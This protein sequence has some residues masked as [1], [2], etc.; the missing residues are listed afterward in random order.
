M[1]GFI[2][3]LFF[4]WGGCVG[5][6]TEGFVV[7]FAF[8]ICW[9]ARRE[10]QQKPH[11]E[12]CLSFFTRSVKNNSTNNLLHIINTIVMCSEINYIIIHS[13][14]TKFQLQNFVTG[15]ICKSNRWP[16][17]DQQVQFYVKVV[18]KNTFPTVTRMTDI[19]ISVNENSTYI[20]QTFIS[21]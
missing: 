9:G 20:S 3:F 2:Y 14:E 16:W 15:M 18:Q 17:R 19:I 7:Q 21:V 12:P 5:S 1:L 6:F 4:F 11:K 10:E 13:S 8:F